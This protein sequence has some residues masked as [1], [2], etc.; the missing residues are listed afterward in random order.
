MQL[1]GL[2]QFF[3][4][5]TIGS[6]VTAALWSAPVIH[7]AVDENPQPMRTPPPEYPRQLLAEQV[8]GMVVVEV[9]IDDHG[10][11]DQA[12]IIKSTESAFNAPSIEAVK[13][14]RFRPAKKDGQE[15]WMRLKLPLKFTPTG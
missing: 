8:A 3:L 6:V 7:S 5:L 15:V 9:V 1:R 10:R 2:R 4:Q 11:V 12:E 13:K 14:W